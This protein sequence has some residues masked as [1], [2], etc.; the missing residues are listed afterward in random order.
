MS[1]FSKFVAVVLMLGVIG[2]YTPVQ[3][4]TVDELNAQIQSLLAMIAQLQGQIAGGGSTGGSASYTYTADLTLGS[5]GADVTALQQFLVS[6]GFLTM[7]AGASYG[8]FGPL[9]KSALA[10]YQASVGISPAAGYFGPITRAHMNSMVVV[11][12]S[13]SPSTAPGVSPTPSGLSGGVGNIT[14]TALSTYSA[15]QVGEGEEDVK[16]LAFDVEADDDSDVQ[17]TA[18]KVEFH[19]DDTTGSDRD[20]PDYAESVSVFLEGD[21]VGEEDTDSFSE[22]NDEWSKNISL[23]NAIIRAGDEMTVAIAVSAL[24]NLDSADIDSD[25][26]SVGVSSIRFVDGTGV[27]LT[28]SFTL[29]IDDDSADETLEKKFD[30]G[31]FADVSD[32][33]LKVSLNNDDDAI[34]E[35][36]VVNVNSGSTDTDNVEVLSFTLEAE[37]DSDVLVKDIPITV[38]TTGETDESVIIKA[39]NLVMDG[40]TLSTKDVAAGGAVTF[41]DLDFTIDAGDTVELLVTIDVQDLTGTLDEGDTAQ[42]RVEVASIQAE[43]ESGEDL[44]TADLTGSA[45]GEAVTFYDTGIIVELISVSATAVDLSGAQTTSSDRGTY[46][47]VFDVTAFDAAMYLDSTNPSDSGGLGT[48]DLNI[49]GTGTLSADIEWISGDAVTEGSNSFTINE[50]DT[51]RFKISATIVAT[52]TGY[53]GISLGSLT[54]GTTSDEDGDILYNFNL[55]DFKTGNVYLVDR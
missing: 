23:S 9:T 46:E 52:S 33:E 3:A 34:N 5:T 51:A 40:E 43:D 8:Y 25:D 31:A 24:T 45:T 36:H 47:I 37:G 4:Q 2:V 19:E 18:I 54:Y 11:N 17:L 13:V 21:K 44:A 50:D 7:P 32:A 16:I 22:S 1:K 14:V 30:F 41:D 6:K 53:T 39:A 29:D 38:T 28:E 42:A 49:T 10:S 27:S 12:P 55:E 35:A 15:E 48:H 26:W 20:L